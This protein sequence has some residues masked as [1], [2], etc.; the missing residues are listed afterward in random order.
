MN[1]ITRQRWALSA[2]AREEIAVMLRRRFPNV[3]TGFLV[4]QIDAAAGD[5]KR[6]LR[7]WDEIK[8]GAG[9]HY[10]RILARARAGKPFAQAAIE[11]DSAWQFR[12]LRG[13]PPATREKAALVFA[14][15]RV[16]PNESVFSPRRPIV[17]SSGPKLSPKSS[18]VRV[19]GAVLADCGTPS[20]NPYKLAE[21]IAKK[22]VPKVS[23]LE[24]V[25]LEGFL[26]E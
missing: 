23:R 11:L 14:L 24:P 17:R 4:A 20:K 5:Y 13:R 18:F 7:L 12:R 16:W 8:V 10:N 15:A 3:H 6:H 19:L 2:A 9:P 25:V 22:G 21:R 26:V 1:P